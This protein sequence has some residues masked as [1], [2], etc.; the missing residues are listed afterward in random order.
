MYNVANKERFNFRS[1]ALRG[2]CSPRSVPG[3]PPSHDLGLSRSIIEAI[4][5]RKNVAFLQMDSEFDT[6]NGTMVGYDILNS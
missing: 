6:G 3:V 4:D 5:N 2:N 1:C